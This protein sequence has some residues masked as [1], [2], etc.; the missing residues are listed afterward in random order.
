MLFY[1]CTYLGIPQKKNKH[2]SSKYVKKWTSCVSTLF[3]EWAKKI[4]IVSTDLHVPSKLLQQQK[5]PL[6]EKQKKD[7]TFHS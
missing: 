4:F 3:F 7:W 2:G 5:H 6:K 1:S